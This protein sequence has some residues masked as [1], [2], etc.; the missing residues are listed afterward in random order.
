[1]IFYMYKKKQK[2]KKIGEMIYPSIKA[3]YEP[4]YICNVVNLR[5]NF[6]HVHKHMRI[7]FQG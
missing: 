4:I 6:F 7:K 2:K 5:E 1:M 3:A